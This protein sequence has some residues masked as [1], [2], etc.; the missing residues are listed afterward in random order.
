M[1]NALPDHVLWGENANILAPIV[2]SW[3]ELRRSERFSV[4]RSENALPTDPSQ[5]WFGYERIDPDALGRDLAGVILRN[6]LRPQ[7]S[8]RVTG[9]KEIRWHAEADLFVPMLEF[10]QRYMPAAHFIFNTRDHAEVARSGWWKT[11][12]RDVVY[13]EL[14]RAEALYASWQEAHPECSLAM[15]YNDYISG[16][17]AWR[18]LFKFLDMPFDPIAV[19][20]VLDFKLMHMKWKGPKSEKS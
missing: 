3:S 4:M 15:H 9:F 10:L 17:D 6:V 7:A 1:I 18:A 20:A 5:P 19:Q 2:Q 12:K 14:E 16:P 11:M 13:A 8:T